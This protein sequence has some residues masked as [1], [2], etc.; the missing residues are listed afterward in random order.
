MMAKAER[1]KKF[2]D[3]FVSKQVIVKK[4]SRI[5]SELEVV[6]VGDKLV[7]NSSNANYSFGGLHRV[8]QQVFKKIKVQELPLK[9][10]LVLGF[11]AGSVVSI[12]REEL[13]MSPHIVAVEI[14]PE[15][16]ELGKNYFNS[17][18][19]TDFDLIEANAVDFIHH[20]RR[21]Y[22]LIIVDV[23]VDFK[24]P[25]ECEQKEFIDDLYRCLAPKGRLLFNK[26]IYNHESKEEAVELENMFKRLNG[27][28]SVVKIREGMLNKIIVFQKS[29]EA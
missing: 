16:I 12:L 27:S 7:L 24:V 9:E 20:E 15:V 17:E 14:D 26:M 23:Y 10:V 22:D 2:I 18:R 19:F 11:G 13:K 21:L 29:R 5:N 8:F 4:Q 6:R 1:F 28:T 3:R 25:S